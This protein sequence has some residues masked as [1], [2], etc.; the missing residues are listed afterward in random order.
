MAEKT[1]IQKINIQIVGGQE[2]ERM[3][4]QSKNVRAA[5]WASNGMSANVTAALGLGITSSTAYG[6]DGNIV[7]STGRTVGA[8]LAVSTTR[9]I[10]TGG[11]KP[12]GRYLEVCGG[13]GAYYFGQMCGGI[14]WNS[15]SFYWVI[16]GGTG[17]GAGLSITDGWK[18]TKNVI[19]K[20]P[21][22]TIPPEQMPIIPAHPFN[23]PQF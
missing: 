1:V 4:N 18:N 12:D 10:L 2:T 22:Y 16:K 3:K 11:N 17:A 8:G 21:Q 9:N 20:T 7:N 14:S 6:G 23:F 15:K 5:D 13:I 19:P